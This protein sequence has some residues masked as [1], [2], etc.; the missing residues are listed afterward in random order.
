MLLSAFR[1][2]KD[3]FI[4]TSALIDL[5]VDSSRAVIYLANI[6]FNYEYIILIPFLIVISI[7]GKYFGKLILKFT[8]ENVF[9]YLVLGLIIVISLFNTINF[10]YQYK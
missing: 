1:L 9:R 7:L 6:Y 2:P 3:I 5:G 10:L 4:A 8:S